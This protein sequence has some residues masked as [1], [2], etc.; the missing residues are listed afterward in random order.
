MR[1][2]GK[3]VHG[4]VATDMLVEDRYNTSFWG[5]RHKLADDIGQGVFI[6]TGIRKILAGEKGPDQTG[7]LIGLEAG[8]GS[9]PQT[10]GLD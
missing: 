6:S 9:T 1:S 7:V 10:Q 8:Q 2:L 5:G 4:H 3:Q